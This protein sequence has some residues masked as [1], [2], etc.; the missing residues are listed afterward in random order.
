MRA[1]TGATFFATRF[2]TVSPTSYHTSTLTVARLPKVPT[3][4]T[5]QFCAFRALAALVDI[6][7]MLACLCH[8][9][10]GGT[11][12]ARAALSRWRVDEQAPGGSLGIDRCTSVA[13]RSR[14]IR[15]TGLAADA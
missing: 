10:V 5:V 8:V 9:V 14:P 1:W 12:V 13:D 11:A 3:S 4:L 6:I 15:L 2:K 7:G